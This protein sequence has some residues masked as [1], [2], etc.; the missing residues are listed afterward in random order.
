VNLGVVRE[1]GRQYTGGLE[2]LSEKGW[3][4]VLQPNLEW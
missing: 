3:K 1:S 2:P 4:L